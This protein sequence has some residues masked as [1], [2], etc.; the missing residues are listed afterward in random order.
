[1]GLPREKH[2]GPPSS[3]KVKKEITVKKDN[4][5]HQGRDS[6]LG[7]RWV[8]PNEGAG[9]AA[10]GWQNVLWRRTGCPPLEVISARGAGEGQQMLPFP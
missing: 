7:L 6:N 1:M 5:D 3:D 4:C 8:R 9:R 10:P 2:L